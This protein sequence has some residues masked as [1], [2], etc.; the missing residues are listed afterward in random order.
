MLESVPGFLVCLEPLLLGEHGE[1][2]AGL[3]AGVGDGEGKETGLV[4]GVE[5]E[6][7]GGDYEAGGSL[8]LYEAGFETVPGLLNRFVANL[9]FGEEG[10]Y[11][12]GC[13]V[14]AHPLGLVDHEEAV[15]YGFL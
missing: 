15:L 2:P 4:L 13:E 5:L 6:G 14:A 11:E 3:V 7:S 12:V 1:H 9:P 10:A 8:A